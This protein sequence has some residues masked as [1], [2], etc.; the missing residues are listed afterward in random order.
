M[1]DLIQELQHYH[2]EKARHL[3]DLEQAVER[4]TEEDYAG[5][6]TP[7]LRELFQPF[8]DAME[9]AHHHNEEIILAELRKTPASIHRRV[10]E[11]SGDHQAFNRITAEI[12]SKII[13]QSVSCAE[14]CATITS[15]VA[16][17]KDHAAGEENIFFPMADKHLEAH[18]WLIVEKAWQ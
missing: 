6:Y 9:V 12:S 14:L 1:H 7:V 16:T 17:Y 5:D 13:N 10:E 3:F 15:F 18:H 11:I 8:Q 4:L 2:K